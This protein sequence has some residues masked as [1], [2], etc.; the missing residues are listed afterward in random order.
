MKTRK[1]ITAVSTDMIETV[2]SSGLFDLNWVAGSHQAVIED[3]LITAYLTGELNILG[4]NIIFNDEYYLDMYPDI[5]ESNQSP[6]LH[7]LEWGIK[8]GRHPGPLLD[9]DWYVDRHA[10]AKG[11][12]GGP[13]GHYLHEGRRLDHAPNN[14]FEPIWYRDTYPD[15]QD[16]DPLEHYVRFGASELRDPGPTFSTRYYLSRNPNL[17]GSDKNPLGDCISSQ[18]K[19]YERHIYAPLP[20]DDSNLLPPGWTHLALHDVLKSRYGSSPNFRTGKPI[21]VFGTHEMSRTGAPLI[22]LKLIKA[23]AE[24]GFYEIVTF[25]DR[26]GELEDDFRRYSHIVDLTRHSFADEAFSI[27]DMIHELGSDVRLAICNTANLNHISGP[28]K[29]AGIPVIALVHEMLYVYPRDYVENIYRFSDRVI[30]PARFVRD[31]ANDRSPIPGG[32]EVV[33]GQGLLDP[34][35]GQGDR[36]TARIDIR[37]E[38]GLKEDT[39][40]VLGCG[41]VNIRKGVDLFISVA[42]YVAENGGE[43][44][45]FLWLG[46]QTADPT[47]AY[48]A[49]KDV[50]TSGLA[51]VVH[52]VGER[53]QPELYYLG[54]D[55]F[56]MTSR[57]DPFPCVIHEAMACGLP[58]ITFA[59]AGGA[60]EALEGGCGSVVPYRDTKAMG[61]EILR[62]IAD[63]KSLD[64]MKQSAKDRVATKYRFATYAREI[65]RIAAEEIGARITVPPEPALSSK[66]PRVLFFARD[67]WISGVNSFTETLARF[68]NENDVEAT[69]VFP[70]MN[71]ANA[72]YLPNLPII[73]L[74]LEGSAVDQWKRLSDFIESQAPCIIVPN[75]DYFTSALTPVLP[76]NVGSIGIIHS[77]DVEHY[78]HLQRLGR[79]WN[80]IICSNKHLLNETIAINSDFASKSSIIPYGVSVPPSKIDKSVRNAGQPLRLVYC[81]RLTQEQKRVRD[82]V[83]IV[84]HLRDRAVPFLLRVIGE[85]DQFDYLASA[86]ADEIKCGTVEMCGRL[87]RQETYDIYRDSDALL[88]V[89]QFEGMPIALIEAMACGCVPVV[90]DIP[91]GIPDLVTRETGYRVPIG[92]LRAFADVVEMLVA[93]PEVVREKQLAALH[94]IQVG[95]F[96]TEA[97]GHAY[98]HIIETIWDDISAGSYQRPK[99]LNWRSPLNGISL[100]G[101]MFPV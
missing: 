37:R 68:L 45:C 23:F 93:H 73:Q 14:I 81:G 65:M 7:Y 61:D 38:F 36:D 42:R 67:W 20:N 98:K 58:T 2:K 50:L 77:D 90:T 34:S 16:M 19:K 79:Y 41:T 54:S 5:L 24:T 83:G 96:T 47:Y 60:P 29:A 21:V 70:T 31:V 55:L 26:L 11:Y 71:A 40:V 46:S 9:L 48:W 51:D 69:L 74:N 100:P 3:D 12:H 94:H 76:N 49:K 78:D 101:Y 72:K 95:G 80:V 99:S 8:E 97:M 22:I 1:F 64:K 75:Y 28:F 52:F 56:A 84:K 87:T 30:F 43:D 82:L 85:G 57:E 91:S 6:F 66:K 4:P 39:P 92:D 13:V 25:A 15:I 32:K 33:L 63:R 88:L 89:S 62:L 35:F 18:G 59:D 86:W 27:S 44:I 17:I 10:A 53:A